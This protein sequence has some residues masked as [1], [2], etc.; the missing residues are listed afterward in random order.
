MLDTYSILS[1]NYQAGVL[2][3]EQL[4]SV[5][6]EDRIILPEHVS[7]SSGVER[8]QGVTVLASG[9]S[10]G[11]TENAMPVMEALLRQAPEADLLMALNGPRAFSGLAGG[12]RLRKS[13]AY[14]TCGSGWSRWGLIDLWEPGGAGGGSMIRVLISWT[15]RSCSG[16]A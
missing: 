13:S 4:I 14:G 3:A 10:D 2:C 15:A 16:R 7:A 11:H 9:E 8:I 12:G 6:D 1:D 5:R